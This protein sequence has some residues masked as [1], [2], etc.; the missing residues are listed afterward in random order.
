V[1]LAAPGVSVIST[2]KYDSLTHYWDY[3][4]MSGTSMASPHVAGLAAL[5]RSLNPALT[6][7]QVAAILIGTTDQVGQYPYANGWNQYLGAGRINARAAIIGR[8]DLSGPP[9][10]DI[11]AP[12]TY[13]LSVM[14]SA[15]DAPVS[16]V[17]TAEVPAGAF[18][19]SASD[20]GALAGGVV[21]W[22]VPPVAPLAVVTRSLVVTATSTITASVFGG[23]RGGSALSTPA[24]SIVTRVGPELAV[25][26]SGPDW[27]IAGEPITY[28]LVVTNT[29]VQAATGL[30][31]TDALPAGANLISTGGGQVM[32]GVIISWT[33][34]SLAPGARLERTLVISSAATVTN[35]D[36]GVV[37]LELGAAASRGA[38]V[39]TRAATHVTY[40]PFFV[41][42][43]P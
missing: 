3:A 39:Q 28:A 35:A 5:I 12:I 31:L 8:V 1:D 23:T 20:G 38:A 6:N 4:Q 34:A 32:P 15:L 9:N 14:G 27:V 33:A 19:V 2:Y 29:G 16:A 18:F 36:Y 41:R 7:V 24:R 17:I 13:L 21:S 11:G 25:S 43:W 37:C 42:D 26:K 30:V 22:T 40:W 10:A